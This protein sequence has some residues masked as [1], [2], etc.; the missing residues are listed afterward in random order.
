MTRIFVLNLRGNVIGDSVKESSLFRFLKERTTDAYI[1]TNGSTVTRELHKHNPDVD[2]FIYTPDLDIL[3]SDA[4]KLKKAMA[5]KK[6]MGQ[7]KDLLKTYEVV[8]WTSMRKPSLMPG[9]RKKRLLLK[10]AMPYKKFPCKMHFT[11][12]EETDAKKLVKGKGKK[13]A[14]N[15]ESKDLKRCW[16]IEDYKKLIDELL[17]KKYKI[18]LLGT[19]KEY[20][21]PITKKYG[22]KITN[23]VGKTNIRETALVIKNMNLY[24]GNDSGLSHVAAAVDTNSITIFMGTHTDILNDKSKCKAV[25]LTDPLMGTILEEVQACTD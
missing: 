21:E 23:L 22:K 7:L 1:A 25:K 9:I 13:I 3:T 5:M 17:K 8:V 4:S 16:G 12:K 18:Y 6:A 24:I 15:I 14:L 11:K 19:D 10:E 2:E 20:N